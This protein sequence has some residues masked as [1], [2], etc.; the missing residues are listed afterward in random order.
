MK[1]SI[2]SRLTLGYFIIFV[3][4][5]IVNGYTLWQ[6]HQISAGTKQ[7]INIDDRILELKK[8]LA[9]TILS[10]MEYEKKFIITKDSIFHEQ[11]LSSEN[12][13]NNHLKDAFYIVNTSDKKKYLNQIKNNYTLYY[14]LVIEETQLIKERKPFSKEKNEREKEKLIDNI[15]EN[16]KTLESSTMR[17][18]H[19]RMSSLS[20]AGSSSRKLTLIMWITALVLV[21]F[22][23]L[24]TTR[25]ITKPLT[26]LL[27]K[28]KE[29]S[30]G[31]FKSDLK[32]GS[33]PEMAEVTSAFNVMCD[34]LN[35]VDKMKSDFFSTMSHELRTPLA[36]IKEGIGL[37][38]EGVGGTITD[39]QQRLLTIL[40][41]ESNRL[42]GLVNSLLDIAKMEAGMMTYHFGHE[43]L[44]PLIQRSIQEISPLMEAKKIKIWLDTSDELPHEKIDKERMLQVLRNLISNA[45]KFTPERGQ[46]IISAYRENRGLLF[47]V[48]DTGPGIPKENLHAI[49]EKFHQPPVKTSEWTKGTGLGLAIVKNIIVAHG[50]E[51]WA[52]SELGQGSTF[53]VLLPS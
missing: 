2:F 39:R 25:S 45:V 37:L 31:I 32:I 41:E 52:E 14:S 7:I 44:A 53:F 42:I 26:S 40:T 49:F 18:V 19:M 34:K 29:I 21:L 1:L 9:D 50:G 47:S 20:E 48:Q 46:I 12:N 35:K 22:T 36:S 8:K 51:V 16:L 23:S 28:T 15:L 17:D 13:F 6:L 4:M 10:Q 33:P 38:Q 27:E 24:F 5:G 30:K 11:F 3:I 43:N